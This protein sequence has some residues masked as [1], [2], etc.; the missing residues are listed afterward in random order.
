MNRRKVE[1]IVEGRKL[2]RISDRIRG[3]R[4]QNGTAT[5]RG[6]VKR[7]GASKGGGVGKIRGWE[8]VEFILVRV[9]KSMRSF[10]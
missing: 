7:K 2:Y 6:L 10:R 8:E 1:I 3:C 9:Q 5:A 4:L